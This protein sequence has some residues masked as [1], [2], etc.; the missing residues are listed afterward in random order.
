MT[1][2]DLD[3][4]H[5]LPY[6]NPMR[7][8]T[9]RTGPAEFSLRRAT[10]LTQGRDPKS[11]RNWVLCCHPVWEAERG[12]TQPL[13]SY[14]GLHG[15]SPSKLYV[16]ES[17][18]FVLDS[19]RISPGYPGGKELGRC[20]VV[21]GLKEGCVPPLSRDRSPLLP[22]QGLGFRVQG[23]GSK[24]QGLGF[25]VQG[26]GKPEPPPVQPPNDLQM[27]SSGES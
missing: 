16:L 10:A 18:P 22:V 17:Y 20:L 7:P 26:L 8:I 15:Y 24:V 5:N 2:E 6:K 27:K 11:S 4:T 19:N 1:H 3:E 23:L 9:C 14:L 25:M 21:G 13:S 12:V